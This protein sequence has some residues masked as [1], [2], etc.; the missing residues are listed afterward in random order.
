MAFHEVQF[1]TGL[2]YGSA[3]GPGWR[4]QIIELQSG[5][6]TRI[7][8]YSAPRREYNARE[9]IK[10]DA[11]LD[12]LMEFFV[13]RGGAANGF[14]FHDWRDH[15][16]ASD[17]RGAPASTDHQIGV[18]DGSTQTFQ[19]VKAYTSGS[20]TH[21][22]TLTKP[23]ASTTVVSLDDVTQASGWSVNTATGVVTFTTAPGSGVIVKAGCE[24]DVPVRFGTEI[25]VGFIVSQDSFDAGSVPDIPLIEILDGLTVPEDYDYG[26][27]KNHGAITASAT[28]SLLEGRAHRF[29]QTTSSLRVILP[30]PD[31]IQ[32]GGPH[33]YLVNAGTTSL[34]IYEETN[35][36]IIATLASG[37]MATVVLTDKTGGGKVWYAG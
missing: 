23:V 1:P 3:G 9:A 24:F 17:H 10:S 36:T 35:T 29:E 28:I 7:S 5:A 33:F 30:Y 2:S 37:D 16:T 11:D 20:Q 4:T 8:R 25:D 34:A 27:S 13:A 19:L 32:T 6:E 14:R 26:G 12:A 18:G 31:D 15:S 22:R 21:T